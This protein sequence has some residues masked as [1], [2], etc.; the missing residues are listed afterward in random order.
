MLSP[1]S[2]KV[3][4]RTVAL[5]ALLPAIVTA[6]GADESRAT[7]VVRDFLGHYNA[8]N[9]HDAGRQL[10]DGAIYQPTSG[11]RITVARLLALLEQNAAHY[12]DRIKSIEAE[13]RGGNILVR[14][15]Y[16]SLKDGVRTHC[17]TDTYVT[18]PAGSRWKIM[19]IYQGRPEPCRRESSAD[20]SGS[21]SERQNTNRRGD[22]GSHWVYVQIDVKNTYENSQNHNVIFISLPF[23][24]NCRPTDTLERSALEQAF[25]NHLRS[26]GHW[27]KQGYE[28]LERFH[29]WAF[30]GKEVAEREMYE[31]IDMS[32][33]TRNV[34][35][36]T[37]SH[38]CSR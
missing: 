15:A 18:S 10:H 29:G 19:L 11:Q 3:A 32:A 38:W 17:A 4:I 16:E 31:T 1:T 8:R 13:R 23:S 5:L 27:R 20:A 9:Y 6:Q 36:V 34:K 26:A 24:T 37:F 7:Q 28:F 21:G 35:Q 33:K 30:D 22:T 2:P 12:Q 25:E 14:P